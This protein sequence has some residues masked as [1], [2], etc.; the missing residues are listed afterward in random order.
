MFVC[1]IYVSVGSGV[2]VEALLLLLVAL[3]VYLSLY[4]VNHS[5]SPHDLCIR[6]WTCYLTLLVWTSTPSPKAS[7]QPYI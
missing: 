5:H 7:K 1:M 6:Y 2:F 3:L 4:V